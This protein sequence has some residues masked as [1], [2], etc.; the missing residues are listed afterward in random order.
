QANLNG[1]NL[2]GADLKGAKISEDQ[3]AQAKT[4]WG[5]IRPE[6]SKRLF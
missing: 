2:C 1:T 4:N 5:T 3:L 6:G